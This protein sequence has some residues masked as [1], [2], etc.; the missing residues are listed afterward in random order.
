MAGDRKRETFSDEVNNRIRK[1]GV[2]IISCVPT[3]RASADRP[4]ATPNPRQP[5]NIEPSTSFIVCCPLL[6]FAVAVAIAICHLPFAI[7]ICHLP[8][9]LPFAIAIAICRCHCHSVC[10]CPCHLPML[11]AVAIC[12]WSFT[13]HALPPAFLPFCYPLNTIRH[14]LNTICQSL[15]AVHCARPTIGPLLPLQ[16]CYFTT[17][18][19]F[20]GNSLNAICHLLACCWLFATNALPLAFCCL[21]AA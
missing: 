10:H 1:G 21:Y 4:L 9:P 17:C 18:Q 6:T 16:V 19:T 5:S 8:L 7:A 3:P 12:C 13:Q 11:L 2:G 15:R 20:T 14:V